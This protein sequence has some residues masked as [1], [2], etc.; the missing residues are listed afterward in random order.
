MIIGSNIYDDYILMPGGI[1][2]T[3]RE[4]KTVFVMEILFEKIM[5]KSKHYL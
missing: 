4:K 1:S 5:P 3:S 2:A